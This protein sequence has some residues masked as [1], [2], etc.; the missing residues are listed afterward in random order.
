MTKRTTVSTSIK[1]DQKVNKKACIKYEVQAYL[2]YKN[3]NN[4]LIPLEQRRVIGGKYGNVGRFVRRCLAVPSTS[5]PSEHFLSLCGLVDN[6]ERSNLLGVLIGG[7]I[8]PLNQ[9]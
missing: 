9:Y 4:D 7:K 1:N 5:N 6:S 3:N 2:I 8:I